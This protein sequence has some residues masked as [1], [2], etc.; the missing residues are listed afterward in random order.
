MH[1]SEKNS[2]AVKCLRSNHKFTELLWKRNSEI[3]HYSRDIG[4][5]PY[6]KNPFLQVRRT[7]YLQKLYF[8]LYK[9]A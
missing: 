8:M 3:L 2:V 9:T 7:F 4:V 6:I 5:K 1:S